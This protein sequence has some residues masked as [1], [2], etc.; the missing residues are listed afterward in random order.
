MDWYYA[1]QGQQRGPVSKERLIEL[2]R[3]GELLLSDLVWNDAM[4]DWA[5][6]GT[7]PELAGETSLPTVPEPLPGPLP[8]AATVAGGGGAS[9]H[10]AR[11]SNLNPADRPTTYLWQSIACL[12]FCWCIPLSIPAVIFA[13]K[14]DP[15]FRAGDLAGAQD[16]SRK[17]R[18]FCLLAL[19][20]GLLCW[21]SI[22]GLAVLGS[23][24]EPSTEP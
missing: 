11:A 10:L 8:A 20:I 15:A 4:S 19:S 21:L 1:T 9:P 18:I 23:F 6:F 22:V 3:A 2:H 14:V 17:A 12:I 24:A 13:C 16:A 5:P 7:L